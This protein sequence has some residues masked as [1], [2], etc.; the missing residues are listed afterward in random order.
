MPFPNPAPIL[1]KAPA[2]LEKPN[3][4]GEKYAL[5][6]KLSS[7]DLSDT[8]AINEILSELSKKGSVKLSK[9]DQAKV[10]KLAKD[11]DKK[12]KEIEKKIGGIYSALFDDVANNSLTPK[13][14]SELMATAKNMIKLRLL[15]RQEL[16]VKFG[17]DPLINKFNRYINI[18]NDPNSTTGGTAEERK[19]RTQL[20]NQFLDVMTGK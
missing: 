14:K 9:V 13:Q 12:M 15:I 18:I 10:E 11:L 4:S 17:N 1:L 20:T 7:V 6:L 5:I 3:P 16:G 8:K 2:P 19:K